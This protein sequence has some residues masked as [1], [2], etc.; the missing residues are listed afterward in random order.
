MCQE[1]QHFQSLALR[2][3]LACFLIFSTIF[4]VMEFLSR[5]VIVTDGVPQA[6]IEY[7]SLEDLIEIEI[8]DYNRYIQGGPEKGYH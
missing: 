6:T 2:T 4:G 1:Q 3:I 8:Y 7:D 5:E